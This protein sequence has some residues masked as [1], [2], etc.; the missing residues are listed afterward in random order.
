MANKMKKQLRRLINNI[1]NKELVFSLR[2]MTLSERQKSSDYLEWIGSDLVGLTIEYVRESKMEDSAFIKT[3][4]RAFKTERFIILLKKWLV[5]YF[6]SLFSLIDDHVREKKSL[7]LDDSRV[8][9]FAVEKYFIR[10]RSRPEIKWG[11]KQNIIQNAI[12]L[13]LWP[14]IVIFASLNSGIKFAK[15]RENLKVMREALWGLKDIG[16]YYFHDDFFVDGDKIKKEDLLLFSRGIPTEVGRL[17]GYCDAGELG[18][19]HFVL[20]KL[21]LGAD[22][23]AGILRRY[24]ILPVEGLFRSINDGNYP[25]YFSILMYFANHAIRYEKIFSNYSVISE[26]GHN[27]FVASHIPESIIC[28]YYGVKYY[29]MHWSDNSGTDNRYISAFLGCD[30]YLLWGSAHFQGHEVPDAQKQFTGYVFKKFINNINETTLKRDIILNALK[31]PLERKIVSFFDETFGGY[32]GMSED[33]HAK[34]WETALEIAGQM[35][36]I[37]I[38]IKPKGEANQYNF[39]EQGRKKHDEIYNKISKFHNV[40]IVYPNKGWSF[41]EIIGISDVVITQGMTSSATIAIICG[42][43]GL[44]LQQADSGH[45]FSKMFRDK[46]VF[47]NPDKL[48]EMIRNIVSGTESPLKEIPEN[49]LREYD[50]FRDNLGIDRFTRILSGEIK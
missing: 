5:E 29:L 20:G 45:P 18:Y 3:M 36:D 30:K 41:I 21:P 31:I 44:Y 26:L 27:Y 1:L 48:I 22:R 42:K 50:A 35:K 8:N 32:S 4:N 2:S 39:S 47:G 38:V 23:L 16:G 13:T 17:K 34:L 19:S 6:L 33:D 11:K 43:E 15:R 12:N 37:T 24:V 46:L 14:F 25:V 40:R 10:F 9:R 28:Q 49:I 7:A